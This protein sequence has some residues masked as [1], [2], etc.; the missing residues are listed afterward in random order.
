[1]EECNIMVTEMGK[2]SDEVSDNDC[3][4]DSMVQ[5]HLNFQK[6]DTSVIKKYS[7]VVVCT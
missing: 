1:M 2:N 6:K 3:S 7:T 5:L 4:S